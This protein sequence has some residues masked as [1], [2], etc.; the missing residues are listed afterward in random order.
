MNG[1]DLR[2]VG[3]GGL[4]P[5][6]AKSTHAY[7]RTSPGCWQAYNEFAAGVTD[8]GLS[9]VDAYA[10]QH[11][12][13][14]SHDRRQR[15]S[16]G[17]HLTA[18]CLGLEFGV[19]RLDAVR[20]RLSATVLPLLNVSEWPLLSPPAERAWLTVE[21]VVKRRS[22]T[23]EVEVAQ[24]R[25]SVWEAWEEHHDVIRAWARAAMTARR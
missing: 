15:Q 3:C 2:C 17:V 11:P 24:W 18:L 20:T 13:G 4:F 25:K 14:A 23:P 1:P 21:D 5:D 19:S 12:D 16:L 8:L 10:S 22:T 6:T 9:H 7:M